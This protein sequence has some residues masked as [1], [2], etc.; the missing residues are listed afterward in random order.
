MPTVLNF[1]RFFLLLKSKSEALSMAI[2]S[3]GIAL[4]Q[5]NFPNQGFLTKCPTN[6]TNKN[7]GG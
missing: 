7:R 1:Q 6:L 5:Y 4:I 3:T 2:F